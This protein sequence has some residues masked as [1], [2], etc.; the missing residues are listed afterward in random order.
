MMASFGDLSHYPAGVVD[1]AITGSGRTSWTPRSLNTTTLT[2]LVS[3]FM[4]HTKNGA[5]INSLG[6]VICPINAM[7]KRIRELNV[8]NTNTLKFLF[9]HNFCKKFF[10]VDI[11]RVKLLTKHYIQYLIQCLRLF[12]YLCI[13]W[14]HCIIYLFYIFAYDFMVFV[15]LHHICL[16]LYYIITGYCFVSY[17]I[18]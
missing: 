7:N 3:W 14:S 4:N 2:N 6:S 1:E 15:V 10:M 12:I 9:C 5:N 11:L 16:E 8:V 18:S 17:P 13:Y